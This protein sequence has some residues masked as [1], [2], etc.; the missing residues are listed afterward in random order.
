MRIRLMHIFFTVFIMSVQLS[1][2]QDSRS[3]AAQRTI[4]EKKLQ[5]YF[6][7]HNIQPIKA[8]GIYY[9]ITKEG[10]GHK[11][12]AGETVTMMYTGKFPDGRVFDSN[13]DPT[14]HH[15]EPLTVEIGAGKVIKGWD[16][17]VQLL[18]KGSVAT[19]YIPSGMAYGPEGGPVPSNA[20]L[21][22]DVQVLDVRK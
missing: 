4:D 8:S 13:T 21:I 22:F 7:K 9:T 5:E 18:K 10:I 16:R 17:G 14:F 19:L 11:I 20:I 3:V 1:C 6:T 2:A 15:T 12:L